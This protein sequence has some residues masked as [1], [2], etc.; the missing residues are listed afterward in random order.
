MRGVS[1][2]R[3]DDRDCDGCR[4][5]LDLEPGSSR[6]GLL[7]GGRAVRHR[8]CHGAVGK[9]AEG[10][11]DGRAGHDG[12]LRSQSLIASGDQRE[13]G[14]AELYGARRRD[15][16]VVDASDG[17]GARPGL[18]RVQRNGGRRVERRVSLHAV[19][20][21][22]AGTS[23]VTELNGRAL[24][25]QRA[26]VGR[27]GLLRGAPRSDHEQTGVRRISPAPATCR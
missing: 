14:G 2:R 17:L 22:G 7:A 19:D 25:R 1:R 11:I 6:S 4:R 15:L 12:V 20:P 26:V 10:S 24:Y 21:V 23:A 13:V 9:S 16:R 3:R 27:G 5:V 8:L 18:E